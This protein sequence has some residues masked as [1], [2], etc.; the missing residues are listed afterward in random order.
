MALIRTVHPPVPSDHSPTR[1]LPGPVAVR[2]EPGLLT[3]AAQRLVSQTNGD[4]AQA[5]KRLIA[6]AP[7][8]GIDLS[9]IF[10]TLQPEGR[11]RETAGRVRQAC[12]AVPG[13]GRTVMLFLSE[14]LLSGDPG[15][16]ETGVRERAAC[17]EAAIGYLGRTRGGA[18]RI[19]QGLPEPRETWAVDS[20]QRAGF[21]SVGELSYMR[22][23]LAERLAAAHS[24]AAWP[25]QV[26][27]GVE[28]RTLDAVA[29]GDRDAALMR[30][31]ERSYEQTLDCP[32]LCGM[33]ETADVLE[34][35]RSTGVFD[36]ALWGILLVE[37]RAE[38]CILLSRCPEQRA[39]ELV[40]LGLS[41]QIRGRGIARA[42]LQSAIGRL[43]ALHPAWSLHCAV[44]RRNAPAIRLYESLGLRAFSERAALVKPM[45]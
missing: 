5:A 36:P 24:V 10:A 34:S 2:V 19:A 37:D 44:D 14:P 30:A 43:R 33:R 26:G 16:R 7:A 15:G 6:S 3:A 17:L 8:H 31:L 21:V 38:G 45:R 40:Y 12:L 27:P 42:T 23:P 25:P 41:P 39:V 9:L 4:I 22:R 29:P 13:A 35:H 32:E 20:F 18:I 1:D 11:V 28:F